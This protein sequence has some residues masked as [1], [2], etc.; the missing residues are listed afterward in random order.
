MDSEK[1]VKLM[2][3]AFQR[4]SS[5]RKNITTNITAASVLTSAVLRGNLNQEKLLH[6]G[7]EKRNISSTPKFDASGLKSNLTEPVTAILNSPQ[8]LE[9]LAKTASS[10]EVQ[11]TN[12]Q[13]YKLVKSVAKKFCRYLASFNVVTKEEKVGGSTAKA[14]PYLSIPG[15][16]GLPFLGSALQYT[17]LGKFS[18]KEYHKALEYNHNK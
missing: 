5:V 16:K 10:A 17:A 18:P 7:T 2:L 12:K 1:I 4:Q 11:N 8:Q 3:R 6:G 9:A 15:P 14:K 13:T